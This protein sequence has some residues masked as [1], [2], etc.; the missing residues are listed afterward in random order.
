LERL[1]KTVHSNLIWLYTVFQNECD[2]YNLRYLIS[3]SSHNNEILC[4][5]RERQVLL[6]SVQ[7]V[8]HELCGKCLINTGISPNCSVTPLHQFRQLHLKFGL[9]ALSRIVPLVVCRH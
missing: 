3:Q 9:I 5:C 6:T 1:H 8:H 2:D 4:T 7:H